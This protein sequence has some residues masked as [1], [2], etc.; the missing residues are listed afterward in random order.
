MTKSVELSGKRP[1]RRP[2]GGPG[3]VAG[4]AA[5]A[6]F[7]LILSG[8]GAYGPHA[9]TVGSVPQDYRTNHPIVVSE[10]P[11][12]LD[13]PVASS[14]RELKTASREIVRG[15]V[16]D[17]RR[18]ASGTISL[19]V[20]SGSANAAA[21]G[22]VADEVRHL[23][24]AEGIAD[25]RIVRAHYQAVTGA[26]AAPIRLAY[27]A[28]D[29]SVAPC[30]HWPE[31]LITDTSQNRNYANFGCASQSNLAAQ[32]ANPSDLLAPRGMT[33]ID[34]ERRSNVIETYRENGAGLVEQ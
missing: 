21:A 18:S 19:L 11:Q 32:I 12:T 23:L 31:D 33:R 30:G 7:G 20:P 29:A 6:A 14:D 3:R 4:A 5:L 22:K 8:C 34:A 9:I 13:I 16:Q 1:R 25:H 26:D 15:Y 24:V 17:Y 2:H 27:I 10:R 28:T